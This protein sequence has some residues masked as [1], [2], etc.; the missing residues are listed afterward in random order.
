MVARSFPSSVAVLL[1]LVSVSSLAVGQGP[2]I[3]VISASQVNAVWGA[4]TVLTGGTR[5]R[6]VSP[7][8]WAQIGADVVAAGGV[9]A[10]PRGG[11][12]DRA[13]CHMIGDALGG[14]GILSN[15]FSCFSYFNNPGMFHF[16][17]QLQTEINSLTGAQQCDMTVTLMFTSGKQYPTSINMDARC[18]GSQFFN[19]NIDNAFPR[20]NVKI[21]HL[22]T[23][24]FP[25]QPGTFS[26]TSSVV[27][28][29]G[30]C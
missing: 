19:A 15:L 20:N 26:G 29:A 13:R 11:R 28:G 3:N 4:T 27:A 14:R 9:I 8:G 1:L 16:E 21:E 10:G 7:P 25:L 17:R 6:S 24:S 23:P 5:A 30:A 12:S 18:K 2:V 22:C